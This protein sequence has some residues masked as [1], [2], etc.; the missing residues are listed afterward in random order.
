MRTKIKI[1]KKGIF[2]V[3]DVDESGV[4]PGHKFFHFCHIN[5]THGIGKVTALF[6]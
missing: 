6:L 2:L 5:V 1:M 3:A 4:K